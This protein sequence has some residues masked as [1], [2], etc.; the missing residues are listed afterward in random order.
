[1]KDKDPRIVMRRVGELKPYEKNPRTHSDE[2]IELIV[3]SIEEFGFTNP[4]L[5]DAKGM[6]VAGHA[7]A[8]AAEKL[9]IEKVPTICLEY[10]TPAQVRAY[11]IAD[12]ATSLRAGWDETL[13]REELAAL[14]AMDFDTTLTG[15]EAEEIERLLADADSTGTAGLTD[16]DVV[17]E[18]PDEAIT[19]T[20]DLWI[21]GEHRLLCGDSGNATDVDRLLDG[22]TIHLVN[23][24]P[25]YNV[26]VEPRSN[27]AIA[28]YKGKAWGDDWKAHMHHQEFGVALGVND[29]AKSLRKMR[30]KDRPLKNDFVPPE[31]YANLLLAW[32]GNMAR[33]LE[34]GRSFYIYGGY[35]NYANYPPAMKAVGFYYS[36]VIIWDK[37]HPVLNRKDFLCAHESIFYGWKEG[38]GHKFFGPNN[39]TDL[40]HVKKVPPQSMIHLT[41]KPVELAR[42]AIEYSSKRGENVMDLFGGSGSTLIAAEQIGRKAFLMEMDQLYCDVIVKRW[43]DFTGKKAVLE[44][45]KTFD[46]VAAE[47][48]KDNDT[49]AEG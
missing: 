22:A 20:G 47:R 14:E 32:F 49:G 6:I 43:Q 15:L 3:R 11:I 37:E 27:T 1:M 34:P 8:K 29:P 44:K 31:E 35:T 38:A 48:S 23:T 18:P 41:E 24:D 7:R 19:Q 46:D 12:N 17:P 5:V 42:R 26:K 21:L 45:G 36:Q 25:P 30:A 13:L 10:L 28:A 33:V 9:G 2:Q 40:W 16:E 39:V 4:I